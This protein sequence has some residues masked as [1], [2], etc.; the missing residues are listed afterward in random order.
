MKPL[1]QV[2]W[3]AAPSGQDADDGAGARGRW[4][5][6][7]PR[8]THSLVA[9]GRSQAPRRTD[10][11]RPSAVWPVPQGS[12]FDMQSLPWAGAGGYDSRSSPRQRGHRWP[13]HRGLLPP[14][15]VHT[16]LSSQ[17]KLLSAD[18]QT[19]SLLRVI[20]GRR[21][22]G[23]WAGE[24][25][26][27]EPYTCLKLQDL[28]DGTGQRPAVTPG[29]AWPPQQMFPAMESSWPRLRVGE[30]PGGGTRGTAVMLKSKIEDAKQPGTSWRHTRPSLIHPST[31]LPRVAAGG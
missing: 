30:G 23:G 16:P 2:V 15:P 18:Q 31:D 4:G 14:L 9:R 13:R 3:T 24:R 10:A 29:R 7:L 20:R 19:T 21:E 26:G 1:L 11:Q 22:G 17:A 27:P 25:A 5:P 12:L 8:L 6:A 28:G